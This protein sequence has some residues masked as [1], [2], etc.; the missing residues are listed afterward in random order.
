[1]PSR[2]G[3]FTLVELLVVVGITAVLIAILRAVL[4]TRAELEESLRSESV[5][6]HF[7]CPGDPQPRAGQTIII[8]SAG[9]ELTNF[10]TPDEIMSYVFNGAVLGTSHHATNSF[11]QGVMGN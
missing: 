6:R 2:R 3:A 4:G 5:F 1:M 10:F 9:M 8:S 7:T 11:L